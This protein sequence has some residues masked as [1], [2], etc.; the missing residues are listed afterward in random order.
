MQLLRIV[1]KQRSAL[2]DDTVRLEVVL[3]DY[4]L[5]LAIQIH[6]TM[7]DLKLVQESQGLGLSTY[8]CHL[9]DASREDIRNILKIKEGFPINRTQEKLQMAA[10]IARINPQKLSKEQLGPILKG[11]KAPPLSSSSKSVL[12][13]SF[14][15][16][17]FKLS[18]ARWVRNIMIRINAG[19]FVWNIEANL[20]QLFTAH[21]YELDKGLRRLLGIQTRLQ[22]QGNEASKMLSSNNI[23]EMMM[24]VTNKEQQSNMRILLGEISFLNSVVQ[25]MNPKETYSLA[26]FHQRAVGLQEFLL[27]RMVWVNFPDYVHIA[28]CHTVEILGQKDSIGKYGA[29]AKEGKNKLVQG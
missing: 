13:N 1:E 15:P 14:E 26:E 23:E 22:I 24:L 11:S 16:L 10:D 8:P 29:Q 6:S 28:L 17:H 9:C 12:E 20:K 7:Q 5:L 25:S 18:I 19:L 2:T 3:D 21:E 4:C 27:T